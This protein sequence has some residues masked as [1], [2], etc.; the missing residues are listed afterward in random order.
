M[1]MFSLDL[2][3]ICGPGSLID[4]DWESTRTTKSVK[5]C[6]GK[7]QHQSGHFGCD[8]IQWNKKTS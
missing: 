8:W 4:W 7:K 3:Y 5:F 1:K 2:T 6:P